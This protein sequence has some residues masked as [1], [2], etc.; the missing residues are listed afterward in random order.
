MRIRF[1]K[2][3]GSPHWEYH[4]QER[5]ADGFG[6][7]FFMPAGTFESRPGRAAH[8]PVDAAFY[9]PFDAA[10]CARIQHPSAPDY[11]VYIDIVRGTVF[12]GDE[13]RMIDMDLDVVLDE[14]G[15]WIDDE[16]EFVEH[17]A[18]YRYPDEVVAE[19]RAACADAFERL[20]AGRPPFD[21]PP[22][23]RVAALAD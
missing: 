1:T 11:V 22:T 12:A 19:A 17:A 21:V 2:Y 5:Q 6:Q 23:E 16:D 10:W 7:W 8:T 20:R 9:V 4:A 15:V 13:V 3:D 14:H 18:K